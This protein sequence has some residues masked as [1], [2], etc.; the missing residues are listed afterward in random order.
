MAKW[1]LELEGEV[2]DLEEFPYWFPDGEIIG[3]REGDVFLLTGTRLEDL[4]EISEVRRQG[5]FLLEE[6]C[7]I[8]QFLW[9]AFSPPRFAATLPKTLGV[10][11]RS[12]R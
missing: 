4:T 5:D 2:A 1:Y 7:S 12:T 3:L 6:A 10:F 11:E 9:T 8:I